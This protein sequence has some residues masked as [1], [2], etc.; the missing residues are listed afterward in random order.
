MASLNPLFPIL[1]VAFLVAFVI[2]LVWPRSD[3]LGEAYDSLTNAI[4]PFVLLLAAPVF[5]YASWH[6]LGAKERLL[7]EGLPVSADLGYVVGAQGGRA[8]RC[9]W[10]FKALA[11]PQTILADYETQAQASGWKTERTTPALLLH[12]PEVTFALWT[13]KHGDEAEIVFEK[14]RPK[15]G[16]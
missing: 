6:Q 5:L 8:P 7:G 3:S 15:P 4:L 1:G 10:R 11:N 12:K 9:V 2:W 14:R 16:N 13:E